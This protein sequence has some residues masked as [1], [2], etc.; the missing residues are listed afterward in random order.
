MTPSD[1]VCARAPLRIAILIGLVAIGGPS[2]FG[3]E[4][5]FENDRPFLA[6]DTLD[7]SNAETEDTKEC[8]EGLDWNVQRFEV[9]CVEPAHDR[10][11]ALVQFPSPLPIG[12]E[13][14]DLVTMEW[15][16]ARDEEMN[17]MEAPAVIVVHES[18]RR[19]T[20]GRLIAKSLAD[21]KIHTFMIQLPG[22]GERYDEGHLTTKE[23][24]GQ[25]LRQSVA[26]VRR[27]KD[28]IRN[29][30]FVDPSHVGL[31]G[32]SLGGFVS[33]TAASL[34]GSFDSVFLM[35]AG[36]DIFDVVQNGKRDAV[37]FR[38]R[39]EEAGF[40]G[41]ELKALLHEVEPNRVAH[42]L[43]PESTWLYTGR[44]DTVVPPRNSKL[45]A[46][47]AGLA[48]DH[49]I[50]LNC[51]HYSGVVYL[52]LVLSAIEKRVRRGQRGVREDQ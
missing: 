4:L 18:G 46:E 23:F 44:H 14:N 33:A 51:D 9:K 40:A 31:Q 47:K 1:L 20:V 28:A 5:P 16:F 8:L 35:L 19:M 2:G 26:D 7:I 12:S 49:H 34:D 27:A 17:V 11:D 13:I 21:R 39:F 45:L 29:L 22:Y 10:C 15:C 6:E 25:M 41:D 43:D 52:P 48:E 42:R 3:F 36:G 50:S 38:E 24:F 30:P 32:T 37:K